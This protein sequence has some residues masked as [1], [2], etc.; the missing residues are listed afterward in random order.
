MADFVDHLNA[1]IQAL[2]RSLDD[3]PRFIKL[4]ELRRVQALYQDH[5]GIAHADSP[6]AT[7][8]RERIPHDRSS[9]RE[10]K[11]ATKLV[12]DAAREHLA[13]RVS[14]VPLRDLY[15]EIAEVRGIPIGGKDPVNN[16]SA[17]LYRYGFEAVGKAGWRLRQDT[18]SDA[19]SAETADLTPDDDMG[20][21]PNADL[22][23]SPR[24]NGAASEI[25]GA[26]SF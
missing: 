2:E 1:E 9:P 21:A 16:L 24:L 20:E 12:V 3:D 10:M 15:H 5:S 22:D 19:P 11:P 18:K 6:A 23:C 17:M 14:L 26:A 8:P 4:R 7:A 25:H 13:G